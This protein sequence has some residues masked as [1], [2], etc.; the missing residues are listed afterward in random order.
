[1]TWF[2]SHRRNTSLH[3]MSLFANGLRGKGFLPAIDFWFEN[4]IFLGRPGK[5]CYIYYDRDEMDEK[6]LAIQRCIEENPRCAEEF[7]NIQDALFDDLF[8][9]CDEIRRTNLQHAQ[10]ND[11]LLLVRKFAKTIGRGPIITIQL[12]GIEA[13]WDDRALLAHEVRRADPVRFEQ[14]K[15][16]LSQSTGKTVAFSERESLLEIASSIAE[17]KDLKRLLLARSFAE[18]EQ[19]LNTI[20]ALAKRLS[21]HIDRFSWVHTEY[22][23]SQWTTAQWYDQVATALESDASVAL[24]QL[25]EIR[26]DAILCRERLIAELGLSSKARRVLTLLNAFVAER[27]WA[28][29]KMCAALAAYDPLLGEAALRLGI[30]RD[31]I[32]HYDI[33]EVLEAL[34][35]GRSNVLERTDGW[36]LHCSKTQRRIIPSARLAAFLAEEGLDDMTAAVERVSSFCGIVANRGHVK[37]PVRVIDDPKELGLF[38]DGEIL[39]TY[40]T[41]MEFTPIFKKAI[42]IITDEGGLSSHAAII[43]REFGLPC[44]VGTRIATRMLK[45][46]DMIELDATNGMISL[47]EDSQQSL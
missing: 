26:A 10:R 37:G 23:S 15:G 18:A 5:G 29:G 45:T 30:S 36:A 28:K 8:S 2:W 19:L 46:G 42:G 22:V 25:R 17:Q 20:P 27:D 21:Q 7:K 32:L 33:D 41:T 35:I 11:L 6:F 47:S 38:R 13:C 16:T 40:M 3:H 1:M 4:Q 14:H 44:V 31:A 43:S 34:L 12:W 9:V 39:V 24:K